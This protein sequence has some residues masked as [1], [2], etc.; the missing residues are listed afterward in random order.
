MIASPSN[1]LEWDMYFLPTLSSAVLSRAHEFAEAPK[2]KNILRAKALLAV[3]KR[4]RRH[5]GFFSSKSVSSIRTL[6]MQA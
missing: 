3:L 2:R 4:L 6:T 1:L 5:A